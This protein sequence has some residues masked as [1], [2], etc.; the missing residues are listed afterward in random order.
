M[1]LSKR[2]SLTPARTMSRNPG[3]GG[4]TGA[5]DVVVEVDVV[6]DVVDGSVVVGARSVVVAVATSRVTAGGGGGRPADPVACR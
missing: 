5:V 1:A 3:G 6:V 4:S 2:G